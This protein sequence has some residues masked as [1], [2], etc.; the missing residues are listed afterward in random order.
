MNMSVNESRALY[1]ELLKSTLDNNKSSFYKLKDCISNDPALLRV[2]KIDD[3]DQ[4]LYDL[5]SYEDGFSFIYYRLG[6]IKMRKREFE[7]AASMFSKS[8]DMI[9][10]NLS[11]YPSF[12]KN[13]EAMLVRVCFNLYLLCLWE[14]YDEISISKIEEFLQSNKNLIFKDE[15]WFILN[16]ASFAFHLEKYDLATSLISKAR[17]A[18][19]FKPL[20]LSVISY[21]QLPFYTVLPEYSLSYSALLNASNVNLEETSMYFDSDNLSY[22]ENIYPV[23]LFSADSRYF[24]SFSEKLIGSFSNIGTLTIH[25]HVINPEKNVFVKIKHLRSAYPELKVNFSWSYFNVEFNKRAYYATSRFLIARAIMDK[26]DSSLVIGDIDLIKN[27]SIDCFFNRL[28]GF[29]A[30]FR[31]RPQ[32]CYF[33]WKKVLVGLVYL[34][35]NEKS[36]DL[37]KYVECY[38]WE[39]F[40]KEKKRSLWGVDQSAFFYAI[41]KSPVK[42]SVHNI[43]EP[44][45]DYVKFAPR[46]KFSWAKE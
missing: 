20:E 4:L 12:T 33:P 10:T 7:D 2:N 43:N 19:Y 44:K 46:D 1:P 28:S 8:V 5:S 41:Q 23:H 17:S 32:R 36:R 24:L 45:S 30:G 14:I 27:G 40:N 15:A 21:L 3:S 42:I 26:Y 18:V 34:R 6:V 13:Y 35:N 11:D 39:S 22:S 29:D 9:L 37:L 31:I 38:F 25:F 16:S